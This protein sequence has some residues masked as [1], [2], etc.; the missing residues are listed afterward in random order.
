MD[1]VDLG[2]L[3]VGLSPLNASSATCALNS[4]LY[5]LRRATILLYSFLFGHD[6]LNHLSRYWGP[7]Q[8][9]T[10][11]LS[12]ALRLSNKWGPP[13][14]HRSSANL[15]VFVTYKIVEPLLSRSQVLTPPQNVK[16]RFNA[17]HGTQ[18]HE[19]CPHNC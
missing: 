2:Q 1:L 17:E 6:E 11:E 16:I 19:H 8:Y 10:R 5:L 12:R 14:G 9:K 13:H 3:L 15:V 7:L 4:A 18:T